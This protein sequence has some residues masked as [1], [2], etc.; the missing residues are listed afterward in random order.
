MDSKLFR[1]PTKPNF[2]AAIATASPFDPD[3]RRKLS[4]VPT[5]DSRYPGWA[6]PMSD[7]RVVTDYQNHCSRNIPTGSQFATKEW[8]TKNAEELMR[9]SR[10]RQA[11][12]AGAIYSFDSTVVPPPAM[13]VRCA[14]YDCFRDDTGAPG[15]IG[16]EREG[17]A[18]PELFGTWDAREAGAAPAVPLISGTRKYEGGRNTPRGA[19]G[20]PEMR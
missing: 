4:Q 15:G 14:T 5:P 16:M 1:L 19:A 18:A 7:G 9:I 11:R 2:Y 13:T 6:G 12:Q 20:P 17:A 3:A 10:Q 8:M